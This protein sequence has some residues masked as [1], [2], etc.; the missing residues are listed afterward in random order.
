MVYD[1]A[2]LVNV[3][4]AVILTEGDKMVKTPTYYVFK[5]FSCHQNGEL[6]ESTL[7][8]SKI[9]LEDQYMV[10]NLHE[11]VSRGKDG[12]IHITLGNLSCTDAYD[13]TSSLMGENIKSVKATVL[14]G[15]MDDYNTFDQPDVVFEKAFD[16]ISF[17]GDKIT[18]KIPASSV[19]H[20]EV[21]I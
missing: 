10:P 11:S 12:K 7:N 20:I 2:Q 5:M 19:M 4:Q 16:D 15:K 3:L 13:V 9:G 14:A 18:F 1:I 6:L 17:E 21:E 8:S